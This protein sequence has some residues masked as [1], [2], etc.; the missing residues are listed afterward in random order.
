MRIN[1]RGPDGFILGFSGHGSKELSA[2]A[3]RLGR[4]VKL[5]LV[6]RTRLF[7]ECSKAAARDGQCL[8]SGV[9]S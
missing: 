2:A 6:R 1:R 5:T 3:Q 8:L 7:A 9:T 4:A